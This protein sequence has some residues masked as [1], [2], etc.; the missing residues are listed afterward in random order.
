MHGS[1]TSGIILKLYHE[2]ERNL[3]TVQSDAVRR[4][5]DTTTSRVAIAEDGID[6]LQIGIDT[7]LQIQSAINLSF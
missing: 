7:P 4:G 3:K 5:K 1:F 2:T 6:V